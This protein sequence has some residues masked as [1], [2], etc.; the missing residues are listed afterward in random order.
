VVFARSLPQN[1]NI[2]EFGTQW[3]KGS[4]SVVGSYFDS[5]LAKVYSSAK[6]GDLVEQRVLLIG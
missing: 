6:H 2:A 4:D 5:L 3:P 1:K